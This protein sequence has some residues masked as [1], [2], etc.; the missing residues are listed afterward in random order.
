MPSLVSQCPGWGQGG[1]G[2]EEKACVLK[3]KS[4]TNELFTLT[5]FCVCKGSLWG[6]S[7]FCSYFPLRITA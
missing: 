6:G 3:G 4:F 1:V 2:G 7:V 5:L